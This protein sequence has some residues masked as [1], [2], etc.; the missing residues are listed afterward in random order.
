MASNGHAQ[1]RF[2]GAARTP[3]VE[4]FEAAEDEVACEDEEVRVEE[5]VVL[6]QHVGATRTTQKGF[7]R[8][9]F[10]PHVSKSGPRW[11]SATHGS[12]PQ[13]SRLPWSTGRFSNNAPR[14]AAGGIWASSS[15]SL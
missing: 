8:C 9:T 3:N 1:T 2:D 11:R 4:S 13:P 12:P 5:A 14:L 7:P 10:E 6:M 15:H